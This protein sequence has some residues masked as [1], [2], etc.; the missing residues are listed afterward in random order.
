MRVDCPVRKIGES[1]MLDLL[2]LALG[3]AGFVLFA[4]GVRAAERM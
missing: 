4:L 3:F 2:Y 1:P